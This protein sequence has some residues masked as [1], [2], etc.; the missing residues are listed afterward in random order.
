MT[1]LRVV[2]FIQ[3]TPLARKSPLPRPCLMVTSNL[4]WDEGVR[5]Y[6]LHIPAIL[7]MSIHAENKVM[8]PYQ[9][10]ECLRTIP[11]SSARGRRAGSLGTT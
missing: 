2:A 3:E 10:F 8:K 4:G 6:I 1:Q 7:I 9:E 5:E 11:T